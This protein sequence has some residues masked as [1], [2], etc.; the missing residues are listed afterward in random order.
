MQ[1]QLELS[2]LLEEDVIKWEDEWEVHDKQHDVELFDGQLD[3]KEHDILLDDDEDG[4][5]V[6]VLQD[7]ELPDEQH[8]P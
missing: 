5:L 6:E 1:L 7:W 2:M 3:E 8:E 4:E